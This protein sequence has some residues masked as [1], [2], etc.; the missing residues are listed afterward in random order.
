MPLMGLYIP[1]QAQVG[2]DS[3]YYNRYDS[4]LMKGGEIHG[5]GILLQMPEES[6]DEEPAKRHLEEQETSD[7]RK[8]SILWN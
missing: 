1:C 3:L 4:A 6:G 8:L 2:L 5:A 7:T